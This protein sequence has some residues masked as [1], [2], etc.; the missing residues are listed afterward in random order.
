MKATRRRGA[1]LSIG[2]AVGLY[3]IGLGPIWAVLAGVIGGTAAN[4]ILPPR[5]TDPESWRKFQ[6]QYPDSVKRRDEK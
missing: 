2:L 3:L 1:L 4:R 6:E 5:L